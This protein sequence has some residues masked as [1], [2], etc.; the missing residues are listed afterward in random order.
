MKNKNVENLMPLNL[1]F[2]ADENGGEQNSGNENQGANNDNGNS[3]N[4]DK[5][6]SGNSGEQNKQAKTFS[7]EEVNRMMA[8]EK[9][10][11]KQSILN[12]LGF[13]TED[14]AKNAFNL[15]KALTDSQKT[16]EQKQEEEKNNALKDKAELEQKVVLA[17]AKLSCFTNGVNKDSIDDVLTIA[18]SKVSDNKSLDDV[19]GEMKKESRYSSFFEG[20]KPNDNTGGTPNGNKNDGSNGSQNNYGEALAKMF[21]SSNKQNK[22]NFF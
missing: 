4:D 22:S 19:I 20:E 2:F 10:Q 17:E 13:K 7:Q 12:S 1:Q 3:G 21:A 18:M 11:G 5:G 6:G 8:N 16:S 9:R 15:L 14:E